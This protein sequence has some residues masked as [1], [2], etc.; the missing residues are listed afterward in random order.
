M[1]S[2]KEFPKFFLY[3]YIALAAVIFVG[4]FFSV[5]F[6]GATYFVT[7]IISLVYYVFD[8]KYGKKLSNYK[9]NFFMF[10]FINLVAVVSI[11]YYESP[12]HTY[13]INTF[14][15][16]LIIIEALS[17]F[18]DLVFVKNKNFKTSE[19]VFIDGA[20]IGFMFCILTYFFDVSDLWYVIIAFAF[21]LLSLVLKIA[22]NY[23][24]L[25][26]RQAELD[27]EEK[28]TNEEEIEEIIR[29]DENNGEIEG[30]LG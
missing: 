3:L 6:V 22:F 25:K 28:E 9:L 1:K 2:N 17:I 11:I 23:K 15:T 19:T 5:K 21:E 13:L 27:Q 30:D 12:K 20:K 14:L 10:D 18:F 4:T 24:N 26:F 16:L 8:K 29:H 7:L